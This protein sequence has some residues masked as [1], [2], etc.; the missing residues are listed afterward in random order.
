MC[1]LSVLPSHLL[2]LG[3]RPEY[4]AGAPGPSL[5]PPLGRP[6]TLESNGLSWGMSEG[7]LVGVNHPAVPEPQITSHTWAERSACGPSVV[8]THF[9]AKDLLCGHRGSQ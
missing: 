8:F 5:S 3:R 6:S 4:K 7:I 2:R 9:E 1:C